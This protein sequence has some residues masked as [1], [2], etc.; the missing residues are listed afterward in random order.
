MLQ[1]IFPD[2]GAVVIVVCVCAFYVCACVL[3][4]GGAAGREIAIH[5]A[6]AGKSR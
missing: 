3:G 2:D 6:E 4:G 1:L 5:D